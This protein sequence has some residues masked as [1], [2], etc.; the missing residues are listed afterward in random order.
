MI[1]HV[2][3]GRKWFALTNPL[4]YSK[5]F[6]HYFCSLYYRVEDRFHTEGRLLALSGKQS[7]AKVASRDKRSSLP[8]YSINYTHKKFDIARGQWYKTFFAARAVNYAEKSFITLN[9]RTVHT[10]LYSLHNLW[11]G[12]IS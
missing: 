7:S 9:S 6:W 11:T 8:H 1:A 3:L 10:K 2:R 4:A 5:P 12:P